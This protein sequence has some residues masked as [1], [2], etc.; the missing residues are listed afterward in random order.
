MN[1]NA[2]GFIPASS[3]ALADEPLRR[4]ILAGTMLPYTGARNLM[5]E[6]TNAE[7]LRSKAREARQRALANLP[8]LLERLEENFAKNGGK[9][10]WAVDAEDA[11]RQIADE[12]AGA[13]LVVKSKSMVTEEIGLNHA[14]ESHGVR[15]VETD[16]GEFIIQLA[17]ETPSHIIAPVIHRSKESISDVFQESLGMG[18]TTDAGEMMKF[19]RVKLREMFLAADVGISGV[20]LA[21]A[22]TG[23]LVIVTNEGNGRMCTTLPRKH[24]AVL[25]LE[26]VVENWGDLAT[27]V[28]LLPRSATG[29]RVSTYV[30]ILHG[31]KREA[32]PD[33][34]TESVLV[35]VDNGRT[36]ILNSAYAE[37]LCCIRCGACL[38]ACPVYRRV[39][40]HAYGW[41]YPGPIGSVITPLLLGLDQ[42]PDLPHASSLCGACKDAC[43]VRIDL[44]E[45]LLRL[46]AEPAVR[47]KA[48]WFMHAGMRLWR[49]AMTRPWLYEFGA[50]L[51]RFGLHPW[52][53]PEGMISD[54]PGMGSAWTQARDFPAPAPRSFR[55][56]YE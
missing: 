52:V 49:L 15:V 35:I 1:P 9:V 43:P 17:G 12:C 24:I 30:N 37:A 10:L 41:V 54:L 11:C 19:A 20:N 31:P 47:G 18:E 55:E 46:R 22:E 45:M 16:L 36:K 6:T 28:Q 4:A 27:I 34:P 3:I 38:N 53:G 26:R 21:V 14:L 50:R 5:A 48:G 29:Q 13:K 2:K 23:G 32:E 42:A 56:L 25:G 33:G 39:G 44:P 8:L 40:G 51:A 7:A